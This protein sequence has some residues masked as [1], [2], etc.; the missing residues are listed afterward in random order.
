MQIQSEQKLEEERQLYIQNREGILID[1]QELKT[2]LK[3]L[4]DNNE[5]APDDEKLPLEAFDLDKVG[6]HGLSVFAQLERDAV[7]SSIT[8]ESAA[9]TKITN[10]I[11]STT[12]DLMEVK[13]KNVRGIFTRLKVENYALSHPDPKAVDDLQRA[14]M[15]RSSERPVSKHDV[16]HPWI[17]KDEPKEYEQLALSLAH[18]PTFTSAEV[19][20]KK[21]ASDVSGSQNPNPG[22][23]AK[24]Y[25]F[26]LSGTPSHEFIIP[27]PMRYTQF[28]VVTYHQMVA[29]IIMGFVRN[30]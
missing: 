28:E 13:G 18:R 15:W 1:L 20:L 7:Q 12:W 17:P 19:L 9:L 29:E 25:V 23:N 27:I 30:R 8:S 14:I 11:I 26:S 10:F 3:K 4:I 21:S 2:K 5:V 22:C 24:C 6:A 16:F